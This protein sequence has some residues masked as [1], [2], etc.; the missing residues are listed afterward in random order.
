MK[1]FFDAELRDH[2]LHGRLN[3]A[4]VYGGINQMRIFQAPFAAGKKELEMPMERPEISQGVQRLHRQGN[5][6]VLVSLGV[7]DVDPHVNIVD[8]AGFQSDSLSK[9]QTQGVCGEEENHV[10]QLARGVDQFL[11]LLYR[12]YIRNPRGLGRFDQWNVLPGFAKH[13]GVKEFQAIEV[14]LY[15]APGTDIE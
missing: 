2:S 10:T 3:T 6:P 1:F 14:E 4:S 12:E 9:T 15:C 5:Q 13:S 8:I 7:T 11:D